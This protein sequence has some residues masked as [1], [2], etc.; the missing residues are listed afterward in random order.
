MTMSILNISGQPREYRTKGYVYEFPFPAKEPT[1]IPD[2]LGKKLV[3][4]GQFK[5][6]DIGYVKQKETIKVESKNLFREELIAL[7]KIGEK[8]A[9]DILT[10]YP[11][12]ELLEKACK[13]LKKLS[14]DDDVN[15]IL[16]ETYGGK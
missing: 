9:D 14:F 1:Q 12:K 4:T 13:E 10:L 5:E 8:T 7:P 11:K 15:E 3:E 2:D 6:C 16:K